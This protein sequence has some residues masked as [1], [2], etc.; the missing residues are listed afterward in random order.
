MYYMYV[1]MIQTVSL[2]RPVAG[3]SPRGSIAAYANDPFYEHSRAE[4]E[5]A[6]KLA[7]RN[8]HSP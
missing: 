5:K 3:S 8:A 2:C 4:F 7:R 6:S 1:R